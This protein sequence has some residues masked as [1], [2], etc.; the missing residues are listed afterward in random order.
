MGTIEEFPAS[1]RVIMYLYTYMYLS[2]SLGG[3]FIL[4]VWRTNTF[5]S[6]LTVLEIYTRG[7]VIEQ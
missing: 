2:R 5:Y 6:N 7:K 3:I 4:T 1:S